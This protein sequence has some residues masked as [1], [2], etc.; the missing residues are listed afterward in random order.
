MIL[1][2]SGRRRKHAESVWADVYDLLSTALPYYL[3][4]CGILVNL[5]FL[6]ILYNKVVH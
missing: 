1:S 3:K 6:I 2:T 4:L 5:F